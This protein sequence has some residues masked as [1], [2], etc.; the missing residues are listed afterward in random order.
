MVNDYILE[1]NFSAYTENADVVAAC[2]DWK[3]SVP[4]DF[5]LNGWWWARGGNVGAESRALTRC[6]T[7]LE[8]QRGC[9]C[10]IVNV[11]GDRR[12]VIPNWFREK[13]DI[14]E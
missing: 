14:Q 2:I 10:Q 4:D 1:G 12:I 9:V 6:K 5:L 13:F 7:R 3:Q 11:R 8:K